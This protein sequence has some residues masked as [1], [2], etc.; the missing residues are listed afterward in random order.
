MNVTN[1]VHAHNSR[2]F[3]ASDDPV[4]VATDPDVDLLSPPLIPRGS[5]VTVRTPLPFAVCDEAA[6]E[7]P[8]GSTVVRAPCWLYL[9]DAPAGKVAVVKKPC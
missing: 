6:A 9:T 8:E 7:Q 5:A 2:R 1:T 3:A 4:A